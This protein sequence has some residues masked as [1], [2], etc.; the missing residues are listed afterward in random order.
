MNLKQNRMD[1]FVV[2]N[3]KGYYVDEYYRYHKALPLIQCKDIVDF[4][5]HQKQQFG[6]NAEKILEKIVEELS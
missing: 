1:V 4:I 5:N 3:D 6:M 2:V